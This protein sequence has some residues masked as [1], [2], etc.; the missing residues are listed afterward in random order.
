[1]RYLIKLIVFLILL[2][3]Y[4][5]LYHSYKDIIGGYGWLTISI[6]AIVFTL[7]FVLIDK[8]FLNYKKN[9]DKKDS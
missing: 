8:V 9:G 1:M 5:S 7:A 6:F 4:K 2:G 3:L